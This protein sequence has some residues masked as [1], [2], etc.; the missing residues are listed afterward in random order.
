[1][2][3]IEL[4]ACYK[5]L[6]E[7]KVTK[8]EEGEVVKIVKARKAMRPFAEEYD[9]FLKDC[10]EKFKPENFDEIQ[11]KVQKWNDL[12]DEEKVATNKALGEY[13]TKINEAVKAELEKEV[14]VSVEKLSES[15]ATK[16]LLENGW[17]LKK[18]DEIEV[19]L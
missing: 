13:Q 1:M 16:I 5:A 4:V 10:Q 12:S 11:G 7:A 18:L 17:E 2:K 6:G 8:L 9:A 19:M 3:L 15:S 14:E